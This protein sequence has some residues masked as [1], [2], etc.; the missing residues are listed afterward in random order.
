MGWR[1]G[2]RTA[3]QPPQ[4]RHCEARSAA[5]IQEPPAPR[6]QLLARHTAAQ[7]A[8]IDEPAKAGCYTSHRRD[9]GS[10]SIPDDLERAIERQV[11]E[12]RA[13]SSAA[14]VQEAVSRLL[15]D[16]DAEQD[17]IER[18]AFAGLADAGAGR[19]TT[20]ATPADEQALHERLM[21]RLRDRLA[22]EG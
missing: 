4:L 19:T 12:G 20:I 5:A 18:A 22:A 2:L 15:E 7:S 16:T 9:H 14:F 17:D 6:L 21:T 8:L 3:R 11:A 13:T 10:S 1:V